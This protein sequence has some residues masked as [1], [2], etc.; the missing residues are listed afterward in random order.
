MC[1]NIV[2]YCRPNQFLDLASDVRHLIHVLIF[3]RFRCF[4]FKARLV[5]LVMAALMLC[6]LSQPFC[7]AA[8]VSLFFFFSPP[9]CRG[10]F[11]NCYHV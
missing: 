5:F 2:Q 4:S 6:W 7:Y 9:N 10:R 11:V 3:V 8:D 1:I